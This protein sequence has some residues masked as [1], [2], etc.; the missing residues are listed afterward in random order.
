MQPETRRLTCLRHAAHDEGRWRR[1]R[2]CR[3]HCGWLKLNLTGVTEMTDEPDSALTGAAFELASAGFR[4]MPNQEQEH[5]EETISSDSASLRE[6]AERRASPLDEIAVRKY[7][8]AN[9]EPAGAD[10][11]ITLDRAARDYASAS[12]LDRFAVENESG[13]ALAAR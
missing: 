7:T 3:G 2:T 6:V 11:A 8:D 1:D 4:R 12:A 10:E 13:K 9:G 5:E